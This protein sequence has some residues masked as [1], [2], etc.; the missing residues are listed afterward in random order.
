MQLKLIELI[1]NGSLHIFDFLQLPE[2]ETIYENTDKSI[3]FSTVDNLPKFLLP[4]K[5]C[6]QQDMFFHISNIISF[7]EL[8]L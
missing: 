7:F 1:V 2:N 5:N 4:F 8:H 3:L 6:F